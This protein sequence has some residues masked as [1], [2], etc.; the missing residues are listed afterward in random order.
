[1]HSD[2]DAN[3][4]VKRSHGPKSNM[5]LLHDNRNDSRT[6]ATVATCLWICLMVFASIE[7]YTREP[8]TSLNLFDDIEWSRVFGGGGSLESGAIALICGCSAP[9]DKCPEAIETR[10]DGDINPAEWSGLLDG[11]GLDEGYVSA[12]VWRPA[13]RTEFFNYLF[14]AFLS[15]L[16]PWLAGWLAGR[17]HVAAGL[18]LGFS[19]ARSIGL[20]IL[21]T[22]LDYLSDLTTLLKLPLTQQDK[23]MLLLLLAAIVGFSPRYWIEAVRKGAD[24]G[25]VHGFIWG[26]LISLLLIFAGFR[27]VLIPLGLLNLFFE[28]DFFQAGSSWTSLLYAT[29]LPVSTLV[30]ILALAKSPEPSVGPYPV[31]GLPRSAGSVYLTTL[32]KYPFLPESRKLFSLL[33]V[34]DFPNFPDEVRK[35][36]LERIS[37]AIEKRVVS[38][39]LENPLAEL[40]SFHT[41]RT[42]LSIIGERDL[43]RIWAS[44]ETIRVRELLTSE[45]E[46]VFNQ[47]LNALGVRATRA[48][49]GYDVH[50]LDY[51]TL[52][53]HGTRPEE[54]W[55]LVDRTASQTHVHLSKMELCSLLGYAVYALLS[56]FENITKV[57][58]EKL[59]DALKEM[60]KEA[61]ERLEHGRRSVEATQRRQVSLLDEAS[62]SLKEAEEWLE[63]AKSS[64]SRREAATCLETVVILCYKIVEKLSIEFSP[65]GAARGTFFGPF[66]GIVGRDMV[67]NLQTLR[68][69]RHTIAHE[70]T[71]KTM[72][73]QDAPIY[74]ELVRRGLLNIEEGSYKPTEQGA[75]FA[76][77]TV[78]TLLQKVKNKHGA[79]N[80][81]TTSPRKDPFY[82]S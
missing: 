70:I 76:V 54:R 66:Y 63:K 59:A 12:A 4:C 43:Q 32:A 53:L 62:S 64:T 23:V 8:A 49:D 31:A 24:V 7:P 72:K 56:S 78:S 69:L 34:H 65:D 68:Y 38:A 75:V 22:V 39:R 16:I 71:E 33:P 13:G 81:Y 74:R 40:L 14:L 55:E 15:Y 9:S 37:E 2:I 61:R 30:I 25:R 42:V 80:G 48:G 29:M 6:A 35:R 28:S 73:P 41:A 52:A 57:E 79:S 5:D 18:K 46:S 51:L 60:V 20:V 58:E 45:G 21:Y 67:K 82:I 1:M 47:V 77:K 27:E 36:A 50:P 17:R 3:G 44:A 19:P 26:L 11:C 10:M